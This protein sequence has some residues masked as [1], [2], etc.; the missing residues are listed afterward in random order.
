MYVKTG[1]ESRDL[2][3]GGPLADHNGRPLSGDF[4]RKMA[5][6]HLRHPCSLGTVDDI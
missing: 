2:S 3:K 5:F 1:S 6:C 4:D